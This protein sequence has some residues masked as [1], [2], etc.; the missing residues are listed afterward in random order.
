MIS[1]PSRQIMNVSCVVR[2]KLLSSSCQRVLL[3]RVHVAHT[4]KAPKARN[5]S[6]CCSQREPHAPVF[7]VLS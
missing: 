3:A 6:C 4:F 1:T 7:A 5:L 2:D